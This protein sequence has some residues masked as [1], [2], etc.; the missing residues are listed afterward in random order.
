MAKK[1]KRTRRNSGPQFPLAIVA[2]LVPGLATVTNAFQS[3]GFQEASRQMGIA[4]LGYD[5]AIGRWSI[6]G[7]WQGSIPLVLGLVVHRLAG[8]LGINRQL[9]SARVPFVRI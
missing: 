2:G 9:A 4:Y 8:T 7:M 6:D 3:G 1:K 5:S